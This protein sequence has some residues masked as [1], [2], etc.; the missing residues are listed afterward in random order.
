M[1]RR[2][3][4]PSHQVLVLALLQVLAMETALPYL[5]MLRQLREA[6]QS[7]WAALCQGR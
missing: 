4:E 5:H 6:Y 2:Y 1:Q 3:L 7:A